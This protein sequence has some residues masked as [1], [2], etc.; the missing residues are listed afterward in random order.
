MNID[1]THIEDWEKRI[2][3]L[4]LKIIGVIWLIRGIPDLIKAIGELVM[5]W[6]IYYVM[7]SQIIGVVIGACLSVLLGIYLLIDGR[8]LVKIAFRE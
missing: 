2:F 7:I 4:S 8:Y 5:R 3:S 6:Y 1:V